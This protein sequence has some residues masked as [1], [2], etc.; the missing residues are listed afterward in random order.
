MII[1]LIMIVLLVMVILL[2]L[3][4]QDNNGAVFILEITL[5]LLSGEHKHDVFVIRNRNLNDL[6][7]NLL[8]LDLLDILVIITTT[9]QRGGIN[10]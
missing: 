3:G 6:G 10:R 4:V 1:L 8:E 9:D 2:V 5:V 7:I